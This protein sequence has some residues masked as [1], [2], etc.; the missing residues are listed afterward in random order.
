MLDQKIVS[1][2][3]QVNAANS[4]D[5]RCIEAIE[6]VNSAVMSHNIKDL[7]EAIHSPDLNLTE[8]LKGDDFFVNNR[9]YVTEDD[10]AHFMDLLIDIQQN[11]SLVINSN[12]L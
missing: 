6:K 10:A 8:Y 12:K 1:M 11:R 3:Q 5:L 2:S 7:F 4:S 9:L